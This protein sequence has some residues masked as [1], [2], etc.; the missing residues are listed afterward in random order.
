[1]GDNN[2]QH[3]RQVKEKSKK[4]RTNR[5]K[6]RRFNLADTTKTLNQR[7]KKSDNTI[8]TNTTKIL[9]T[10]TREE[11][12]RIRER[13]R[14]EATDRKRVRGRKE[15]AKSRSKSELTTGKRESRRRRKIG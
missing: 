6:M 1:M 13:C 8:V 2:I 3:K 5:R 15:E 10:F 14:T 12:G 4:I 11:V 7:T 9:Q